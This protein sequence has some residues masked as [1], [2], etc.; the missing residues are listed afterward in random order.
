MQQQVRVIKTQRDYD[1]ALARLSA[2]MDE[3]ITPGSG[4]EAELELW[5]L[6]I[7]SYE[8][9]KVAP[10]SPDPIAA[11]LFRMDQ[12]GLSKKDLVPYLGSLPKVSEVLSRKRQLSLTM[13]RKIHKGLDIPA[14]IL[15]GGSEDPNIDLSEEPCYDY[16]KFPWQEMLDR[17][18]FKG[19]AGTV[20][21]AKEKGEE[22]IRS[23]MR[24]VQVGSGQPALLRAPLNQSGSRTMDDYALLIWRIA[25]LKKAR[26]Q[27]QNLRTRYKNGLVTEDWL[28]DLAKLS[29]FEQGPRLVQEYLANIGIILVIEEHFKKTYLDGAAM[30]DNDTPVVALTLRHDR[31]DNFWFALIHELVHVQKHLDAGRLFIADDLDDKTRSGKEES[32]ADEGAR[33]A[34]IPATEWDTSEVRHTHLAEHAIVLADRLRVHPSIVAGRVRHETNNWRLL[35][36]FKAGVRKYFEDQL[37]RN[38]DRF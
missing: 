23:F 29:R 15:L 6:V 31:L 35:T 37:G 12:Q 14:D 20:R 1:A 28:R 30:L 5:A 36:G 27:A 38:A 18:Y 33:E 11:I 16:A 17:G 2:L 32:E 34:L 21:Q 25:V 22:L 24:S 13:I 26:L 8:R 19:F 9:S 3:T 7:E 4:K 10:V